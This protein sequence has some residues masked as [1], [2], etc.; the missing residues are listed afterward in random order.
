[1]SI[2]DIKKCSFE[3][4]LWFDAFCKQNNLRYW[5]CGGTLLGAIR[6]KGFIPWDDDIDVMMPRC[7]YAQLAH[8]F[9][10]EGYYDLCMPLNTRG[11]AY[12]FSKLIDNRTIKQEAALR[13][14]VNRIGVDIDIFPIDNI[15][16]NERES[17]HYFKRIEYLDLWLFCMNASYSKGKTIVSTF[18]RNVGV[19]TARIAECLN[20]DSREKILHRFDKLSQK[21]NQTD[22]DYWGITSIGH[23]GVK[24][25]NL[26][27][28][29]NTTIKVEFEGH[30]FPAPIS[31]D[32]YLRKLYGEDYM[33]IPPQKERLT[34][35]SFHAF[36]K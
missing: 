21:Y 22:C 18:L 1:M 25:R 23:Y 16:N 5:L 34:H 8:L 29:Y 33:K 24:E 14:S 28:G 4:L 17:L 7:D 36:W 26:K 6:H 32:A 30:L 10:T 27:Q 3:I 9:P 2:Q 11:Y 31:Y 12:S 20:W 13:K 35:H 19:M 15:P